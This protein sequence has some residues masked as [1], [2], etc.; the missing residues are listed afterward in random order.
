MVVIPKMALRP[1]SPVPSSLVRAARV[2]AGVVASCAVA[3]WVVVSGPDGHAPAAAGAVAHAL[4]AGNGVGAYGDA[5]PAGN[6]S[7]FAIDAPATSMAA[8]H[9]GRGYW[10]TA[11]DGGVFA[12]G[13]A[14][15]LGSMGAQPLSAPVV[16]MAAT[17]D[18]RG[19]WMTALDGGIFAFGDAPFL[20][21]MGAQRLAQ[22]VV[23]MAATPDGSGYW[24]VAAD[25]GIFA[26]GDAP[27]LG[28]MG[29]HPLNAPI[30]GMAATADG[31]GYWLVASDGGV[32]AFG[33][34]PFYGSASGSDI[35]TWVTGIAPTHDD[36]GYW[37]LAATAGVLTYGDAVFH[38]PTPNNP[39][40]SPAAAIVATPDGGGYWLLKPDEIETTFAASPVPP[41]FGQGANAVSVAAGQIGPD[42]DLV[43]GNYCNPYG[44]CEQWC[45]L[46]ATWVWNQVGIGIPR[47]AFTGDV[48]TW[49]QSSG[50]IV[51]PTARSA[52][53]DAILYGTGPQN[54]AT[55]VHMGIV[56][57]TW[58]DGA[59]V[60]V[61][62]DSGPE[63]NGQDLTT[64]DGPFLPADA[65][66]QLG[67][68]VYG[69]VQ[70]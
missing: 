54:A 19:Y 2:W 6:F 34:A 61:E 53:G 46:F 51:A 4:F 26:F 35:N 15:Y 20:G 67:M 63:P 59:V 21:S 3:A 33:D 30:V 69:F 7:G 18:G 29:A 10:V 40:F 37:L 9:D 44:P 42:P 48:F 27:Y 13:D 66:Y 47:Y 64:L 8:T 57:E 38:G 52:P 39:P 12:F 49:G 24:L 14:P 62:G 36:H 32:F 43:Y 65:G 68:P 5:D 31:H 41:A 1:I 55:S 25:G 56:A 16:G 70:P 50:V 17:P 45:A 22:P 60:T 58:P 23:G 11:A 28:S